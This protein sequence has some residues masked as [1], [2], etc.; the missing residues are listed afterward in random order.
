MHLWKESGFTF[1]IT[2]HQWKTT[3]KSPLCPYFSRLNEQ[4]RSLK[5][6]DNGISNIFITFRMR[7]PEGLFPDFFISSVWPNW[8]MIL[9]SA[10]V[11]IKAMNSHWMMV[12]TS[13]KLVLSS[14]LTAVEKRDPARGVGMGQ[15]IPKWVWDP[16][17]PWYLYFAGVLQRGMFARVCEIVV[18]SERDPG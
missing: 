1:S 17:L 6:Y 9:S 13:E 14:K 7:C 4:T 5:R 10:K 12:G 18:G 11:L 15:Y 2:F 16:I 3:A 8:W